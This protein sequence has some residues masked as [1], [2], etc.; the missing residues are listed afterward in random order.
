MDEVVHVCSYM[1][2]DEVAECGE[3]W[4][5]EEQDVHQP[6]TSMLCVEEQGEEKNAGPFEAQEDGG[7]ENFCG[8]HAVFLCLIFNDYRMIWFEGFQG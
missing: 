8:V 7:R 2:V 4:Y 1:G 6:V 3:I 5:E